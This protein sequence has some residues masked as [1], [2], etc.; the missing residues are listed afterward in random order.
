MPKTSSEAIIRRNRQLVSDCEPAA[1]FAF[2]TDIAAIPRESGNMQAIADY[3]AGFARERSLECFRDNL[4]NIVI[5]KPAQRSQAKD[6]VILQAHQDMVCV[7]AEGAAHDFANDPIEF[8]R[9]APDIL[10][11]NGTTLGADDGIGIA[12]ALAVLDNQEIAH[13]PLEALFTIDEETDMKG[14][15]AITADMLQGKHLI[16]I[17]AE[18]LGLAYVSSAAGYGM[19]VDIPIKRANN[20]S[21]WSDYREIRVDGLSGGHSGAQINAGFANAFVLLAR[22]LADA[23]KTIDCGLIT[24]DLGGDAGADNAIPGKAAATVALSSSGDADKLDALVAEWNETFKREYRASDPGVQLSSRPLTAEAVQLPPLTAESGKT[25]LDF[26]RLMP[27]GVFR[28]VQDK[29]LLDDVLYKDLLVETSCNLGIAR[30]EKDKAHFRPLARGSVKSVLDDLA[31]RIEDLSRMAGGDFTIRNRTAGWE[32]AAEKPEVQ[33]LFEDSSVLKWQLIGVHA[34]LECGCLVETF[35]KAGRELHAVS[36]GPTIL[37]PHS[38][39]E[40]LE[41]NT[42]HPMWDSLLEVLA[43]LA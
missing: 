4:S 32:M 8:T 3:L 40:L 42:V 6:G 13:P 11:A 41:I 9:P 39:Q 20:R 10:A 24:F 22:M 16:N 17:D 2:F 43:R 27:L 31:G 7:K 5:R 12:I 37:N 1:A 25:F 19:R 33:R 28:F 14:A 21:G 23:E 26:I 38:P 18:E 35:E 30:L 15:K 29:R 36:A 34:G